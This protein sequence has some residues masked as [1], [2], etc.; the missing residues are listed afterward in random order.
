[1]DTHLFEFR[2]PQTVSSG[3]DRV[4]LKKSMTEISVQLFLFADSSLNQYFPF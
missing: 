1:M 2:S 4:L 3:F